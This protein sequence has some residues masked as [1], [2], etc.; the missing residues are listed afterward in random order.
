MLSK[1][2]NILLFETIIKQYCDETGMKI[3]HRREYWKL[4][5]LVGPGICTR[6]SNTSRALFGEATFA[7]EI[8]EFRAVCRKLDL[9]KHLNLLWP[10]EDIDSRIEFLDWCI[11]IC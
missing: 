10:I 4:Q 3:W 6:I 1:E 7:H 11:K 2:Q 5:G 9:H 8:I